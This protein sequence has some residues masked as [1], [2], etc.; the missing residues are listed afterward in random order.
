VSAIRFDI[1]EI[2]VRKKCTHFSIRDF[3]FSFETSAILVRHVKK[4]E[5]KYYSELMAYSRQNLM[6]FP[7]HLSD[8]II[9]GLV[10]TPFQYYAAMLE[11]LIAQERSYDSLPNF[12]AADC[13]EQKV[14]HFVQVDEIY[15]GFFWL[16]KVYVFWELVETNTL[17]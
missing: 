4:D 16:L 5:K 7:Y 13:E 1:A 14:V 2:L 6:L 17:I 9:N 3:S 15:V 8:V 10:I 12:T 11:D